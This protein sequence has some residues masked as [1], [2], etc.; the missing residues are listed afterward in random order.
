MGFPGQRG[1]RSHFLRLHLLSG[2]GPF[3]GE[4]VFKVPEGLSPA[5]SPPPTPAQKEAVQGRRPWRQE[6]KATPGGGLCLAPAPPCSASLG[7]HLPL[8]RPA[9]PSPSPCCQNHSFSL[10]VEVCHCE[11]GDG[12][13][14]SVS[15]QIESGATAAA[16]LPRPCKRSGRG[17]GVRALCSGD[18]GGTGVQIVRYFQEIL[19]AQ[20]LNLLISRKAL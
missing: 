13:L 12:H 20:F 5:P 15:T 16:G 19:G 18:T 8:L 4:A 3:L 7:S 10:Q 2:V 11:L 17:S 9:S 14:P 6:A 1:A